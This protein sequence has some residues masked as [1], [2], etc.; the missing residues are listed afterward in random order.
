M[1]ARG[2]GS[3]TSAASAA[4]GFKDDAAREALAFARPTATC[5]GAGGDPPPMSSAVRS[6][7]SMRS[8][9]ADRY[10]PCAGEESFVAFFAFFCAETACL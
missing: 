2:A 10:L 5:A 9:R 4:G 3:L 1:R 6:R 7:S 8:A